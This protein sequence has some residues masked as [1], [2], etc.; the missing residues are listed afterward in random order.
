MARNL[1]AGRTAR[2]VAEQE[3]VVTYLE[4]KLEVAR[5][6]LEK[7]KR[8]AREAVSKSENWV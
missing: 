7:R 4:C 8:L 2:A 5:A 3:T 6:E 1:E